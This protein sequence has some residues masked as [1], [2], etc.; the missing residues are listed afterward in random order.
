M[1]PALGLYNFTIVWVFVDLNLT[2]PPADLL[3]TDRRLL[4]DVSFWI[5][6]VNDIAQREPVLGKQ[7]SQLVFKCHFRLD[8]GI[9]FHSLKLS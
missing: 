4:T 6:K 5:K 8:G 1:V 2:W 9:A 3:L 7:S